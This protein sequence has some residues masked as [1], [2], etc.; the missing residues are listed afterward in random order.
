MVLIAGVVPWLNFETSAI[1]ADVA[2][3]IANIAVGLA[4]LCLPISL[5]SSIALRARLLATSV[6]FGLSAVL[7]LPLQPNAWDVALLALTY[8]MV[9]ITTSR[10]P[11]LL[12]R[13]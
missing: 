2:T 1:L 8:S 9:M 3:T 13:S 7:A 6:L 11:R 5:A 12:C 10:Y 4:L